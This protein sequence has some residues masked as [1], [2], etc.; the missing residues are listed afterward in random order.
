MKTKTKRK[1]HYDIIVGIPSYNEAK[2]IGFVVQMVDKGLK[3]YFP[4][5]RALII[6]IDAHSEDGTKEAFLKVKTKTRKK[7]YQF[8]HTGK[9]NAF[10]S[11]FRRTKKFQPK[12]YM[13]VD[14]DLKSIRPWWVREFVKPILRSYDYITPVY[15]RNEYDA[16]ITNFI[17][18]PLLYGLWGYDIRQ[19]IGG[20]F[21]F[22]SKFVQYALKQ[23]WYKSTKL[24]GIDIFLT[25]NAVQGGFRLG[26]IFLG[27]KKHKPSAPRLGP[28]F[29]Q[30]VDSLFRV[31]LKTKKIWQKPMS[32]VR[33]VKI[34]NQGVV[35]DIPPLAV[36]YKSM[37]ATAAYLFSINE[38]ILKES[39]TSSVYNQVSRMFKSKNFEITSS[40]WAKI[41]Y[42]ILYAVDTT[43]LNHH[44][45]E[46]L[47]PLYFARAISF[48]RTTL[49]MTHEKSEKF[50][51]GQVR[52]FFKQRGYFLEKY[53]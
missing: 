50:I 29:S 2:N 6:N 32:R 16:T 46:S 36:D 52:E 43:T 28:M 30:V 22:S 35:R 49:D 1:K 48:I 4:K 44:L 45:I 42:D 15:S 51:R 14:A 31:T 23:H 5:T 7:V 26:Q 10:L 20:D 33:R 8:V 21:S 24:F 17:C 37:K 11:L 34:I 27:K 39:L 12:A 53:E 25:L 40:L 3:R 18:Y 47:K 38:D 19:P 13:V 41:V 9:G